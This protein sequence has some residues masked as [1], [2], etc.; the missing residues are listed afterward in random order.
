MTFPKV[1]LIPHLILISSLLRLI[2]DLNLVASITEDDTNEDNETQLGYGSIINLTPQPQG[3]WLKQCKTKIFRKKTLY[4]RLPILQWLPNYTFQ[5]F[6]ADLVAGIS[7]G[8]TLIPQALAYATVA[9]L[10]PQVYLI[11]IQ[12]ISYFSFFLFSSLCYMIK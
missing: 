6:M 11:H 9:G 12:S 8:V 7:V 3:S 5:D 10:P 4:Q 2:N 1:A